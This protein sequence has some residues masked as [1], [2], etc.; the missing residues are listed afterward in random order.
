MLEEDGAITHHTLC[1]GYD[2]IVHINVIVLDD[3]IALDDA[4]VINDVCMECGVRIP[5]EFQYT[6]RNSNFV[7]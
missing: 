2:V 5:L 4:N 6:P 3:V 1:V 7:N